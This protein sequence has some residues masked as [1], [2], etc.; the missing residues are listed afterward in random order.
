MLLFHSNIVS[1][2]RAITDVSKLENIPPVASWTSFNLSI[3][4]II[5]PSTSQVGQSIW[6][7]KKNTKG[8]YILFTEN[9]SPCDVFIY[10]TRVAAE[11]I[12][13]FR[14]HVSSTNYIPNTVDHRH[15]NPY[16]PLL[17]L[18]YTNTHLLGQGRLG[19]NYSRLIY[20]TRGRA[21]G[22]G[23]RLP[24]PHFLLSLPPCWYTD[25]GF[26]FS[27]TLNVSNKQSKF[28]CMVYLDC[29]AVRVTFHVMEYFASWEL[30]ASG[31]EQ[32]FTKNLAPGS[33]MA[34]S[35]PPAR[36]RC[37]PSLG[38]RQGYNSAV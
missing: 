12:S 26:W 25:Q 8:P 3:F 4:L 14:L 19:E 13:I 2:K 24:W 11:R 5:L 30:K 23:P 1:P 22:R 16:I 38:P 21:K 28:C 17:A 9:R 18:I 32:G 6:A 37:H 7:A 34:S 20:E 15:Y 27:K 35:F 36:R 29:Y 10:M 31:Y 33:P